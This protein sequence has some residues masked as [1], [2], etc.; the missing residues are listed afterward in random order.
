[1]KG[2]AFRPRTNWLQKAQDLGFDTRFLANPPYWVEALE[3]P[4]CIE[5]KLDEIRFIQTATMELNQL[6][7][8]LVERALNS[9][10]SDWILDALCVPA[11]FR[12]MVQTSWLRGDR[13]IYGRFDLAVN[14]GEI[15]LLEMNF[16]TPTSLSETA[17]LQLAWLADMTADGTIDADAEQFNFL[18]ERLRNRFTEPDWHGRLLHLGFYRD[19]DED[20]ETVKYLCACAQLAGVPTRLIEIN[21]LKRT[22]QGTIVDKDMQ[23][24]ENLFK[25]YPWELLLKDDSRMQSEFGAYLF[26]PLIESGALR[27]VEPAWKLLLSSKAALPLL[28]EMFPDHPLLLRAEFE[29]DVQPT[30]TLANFAKPYVRKPVF[31]REGGGVT[32][33]DAEGTLSVVEGSDEYRDGFVRQDYVKL[34]MHNDFNLVVGSW[35]VDSRPAGIGVRAD[36]NKV[37]GRG[38]LFVPHYVV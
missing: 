22:A 18:D 2:K 12:D 6:A 10:D 36:R 25:L 17:L 3:E 37:T 16:D 24:V 19:A 14:D 5:F 32:I 15:K 8:S 33:V 7:L 38:A 30:S 26:K 20:A 1:M 13:T 34:P 35:L 4:F 28:W 11:E 29:K 31:G 23:T 21:D 9:Q 27:I